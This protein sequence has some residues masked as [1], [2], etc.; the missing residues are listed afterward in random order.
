MQ[1]MLLIY[2]NEAEAS[3]VPPEDRKKMFGEYGEFTKSIVASGHF[4]AGDAL[5][6]VATATT[7][8]VR[9]GKQLVTDGPFAETRE[10]LGGYY[11]IEAKDLDEATAIAARIPGARH[12]SIE[13]RPRHV[14]VGRFA[15]LRAWHRLR[16]GA[17][18]SALSDRIA[19]VYR[20][21][22]GRVLARLIRVL[23][24]DFQLAEEGLHDAF[25]AALT[26]W[27]EG[28]V[29]A[30][31]RAWILRA[32]RNKAIDR[33]RRRVRLEEKLQEIARAEE[34]ID[35][36]A[37]DGEAD[38]D[39]VGDDR[40]RLIF[41]CVN[42]ALGVDAQVA[43]TLRTLCGLST[44]EIARAFLVP[45]P[46]M[47]QRLVRAK[48]KI[49]LAGIPYRVPPAD[50]LPER[51]DAVMAVVYL[52]FTEGYAATA[53]AA[54]LRRDLSG[55][56]IR[57]ARVLES[58]LPERPE[59]RALLALMLLHDARRDART[60]DGGDLIVLE[61]QDRGLWDHA[62]IAEGL[63]LLDAALAAGATG[64]Y[65]IQAAIA[66][67]HARASR[68]EDTDWR[69]IAALYQALHRAGPSPIVE[70]N[71]AVAVSMASGPDAGLRLLDAL[72]GREGIRGYHLL[73]AAR[74]DLL[75]RAGRKAEAAAAYTEALALVG[76]DAERRYLARRLREMTG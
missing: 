63:A 72:A 30:E 12:G 13:V 76:N 20:E 65:V 41:T 11:L 17:E 42:P 45:V 19:T 46:T 3:G 56:A 31:P 66:A 16:S 44:E 70:L 40:L 34:A 38:P 26:Q 14:D 15:T 4:K 52:V 67:L 27:G 68:P 18:M 8:R 50:E 60:D 61:D 57:V 59:P 55:E 69:Q 37:L 7:V 36:A 71:H 24:G 6:P 28:G 53:G 54:L 62:Q 10:Q 23:G 22:S 43:L 25:E 49:A 47:A 64:P 74:A 5:Q 1:Y 2:T 32:A 48:Q 9:G 73:P 58:L 33:L 39:P 51:L 29:P 75:R 21:E 35:E